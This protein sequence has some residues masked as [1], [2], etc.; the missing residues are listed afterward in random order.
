MHIHD[1][2]NKAWAS[3]SGVFTE[4]LSLKIAITGHGKTASY[5]NNVCLSAQHLRPATAVRFYLKCSNKEDVF[6]EWPR[7]FGLSFFFFLIFGKSVLNVK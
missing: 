5:N 6:R 7:W 1:T 3:Q 4:L 2:Q